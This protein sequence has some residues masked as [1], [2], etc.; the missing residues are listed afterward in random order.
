MLRP[1]E[2]RKSAFRGS[3]NPSLEN[4]TNHT[5]AIMRT[6]WTRWVM[7]CAGLALASAVAVEAQTDVAL[8]LYGAFHGTTNGN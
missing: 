1:R 8:S 6:G 2:N 4:E 3:F 5:E 7:L